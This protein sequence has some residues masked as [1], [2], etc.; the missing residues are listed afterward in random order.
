MA[1]GAWRTCWSRR[2]GELTGPVSKP[3]DEGEEASGCFTSAPAWDPA[4]SPPVLS[5]QPCAVRSVPAERSDA[6]WPDRRGDEHFLRGGRTAFEPA[7]DA[8]ASGDVALG[9]SAWAAVHYALPRRRTFRP[10]TPTPATRLPG[11]QYTVCNA[12]IGGGSIRIHRETS[13]KRV[14]EVMALVR[15][16]R[17]EKPGFLPEGIRHTAHRP[18]AASLSGWDR[19]VALS[20]SD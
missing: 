6:A 19:I 2:M 10:S 3:T 12:T 4:P 20:C 8:T 13:R 15:R 11:A 7:A 17:E 18:T 9:Y 1:P 14:S 16:G 5:G